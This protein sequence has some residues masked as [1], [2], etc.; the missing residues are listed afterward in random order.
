MVCCSQHCLICCNPVALYAAILLRRTSDMQAMQATQRATRKIEVLRLEF[1]KLHQ[2]VQLAKRTQQALHTSPCQAKELLQ[3]MLDQY[4]YLQAIKEHLLKEFRQVVQ[5]VNRD[6]VRLP[7]G[8][9]ANLL[10]LVAIRFSLL[11]AHAVTHRKACHT[12]ILSYMCF[13]CSA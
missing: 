3:Q 9:T 8:K 7:S 5:Q 13:T 1:T 4:T 11:L 6:K 12:C 2:D 10:S